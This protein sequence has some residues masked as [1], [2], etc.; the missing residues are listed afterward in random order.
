MIVSKRFVS[1]VSFRFCTHPGLPA[2]TREGTPNSMASQHG[3]CRNLV[4]AFLS[5]VFPIPATPPYSARVHGAPGY[6]GYHLGH[7]NLLVDRSYRI[8]RGTSVR[9]W[10]CPSR[11]CQAV[12]EF[13]AAFGGPSGQ[14]T[15]RAAG[16]NGTAA[17]PQKLGPKRSGGRTS[18]KQWPT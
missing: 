2:S 7:L 15:A 3:Q 14:S 8:A 12:P 10:W 1:L 5:W 18:K 9:P 6:G 13:F 17:P 11:T 4:R 16:R